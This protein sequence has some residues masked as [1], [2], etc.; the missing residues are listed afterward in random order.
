MKQLTLTPMQQRFCDEY[1]LDVN[2]KAAAIR[3]GYSPKTA[4][5]KACH[6]LKLQPVKEYLA[7]KREVISEELGLSATQL[8]QEYARI[9]F[10]D[11]RNLYDDNHRLIP[12]NELPPDTAAAIGVEMFEKCVGSGDT[13]LQAGRVV[14]IGLQHKLAA[15]N[16]LAKHLGLFEKEN[17]KTMPNEP[18]RV[19]IGDMEISRT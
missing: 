19:F 15:L 3:A 18:M 11:A 10:F 14:K 12:F 16:A 13:R 6:L 7:E 9:A 8:L 17:M 5:K 2:G 1:L 4:V